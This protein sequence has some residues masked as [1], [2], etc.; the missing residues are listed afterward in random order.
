VETLEGEWACLRQT[1]VE[2]DNGHDPKTLGI[3]KAPELS[4]VVCEL[5]TSLCLRD[6]VMEWMFAWATKLRRSHTSANGAKLSKELIDRNIINDINPLKEMSLLFSVL[7]LW[8]NREGGTIIEW[9][10]CQHQRAIHSPAICDNCSCW[11][12]LLFWELARLRIA[13]HLLHLCHA[14]VLKGGGCYSF[15]KGRA[16][17]GGAD[18]RH[19]QEGTS[20]FIGSSAKMGHGSKNGSAEAKGLLSSCKTW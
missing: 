15:Q 11:Q 14:I 18:E 16:G 7:E 8:D 9:S 10:D 4:K 2:K 5:T 17:W 3:S 19:L 12:C 1:R 6:R 20:Y 13:G